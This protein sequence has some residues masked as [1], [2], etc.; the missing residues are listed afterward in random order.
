MT[1]GGFYKRSA[2]LNLGPRGLQESPYKGLEAYI[3]HET[4]GLRPSTA[5]WHRIA[6]SRPPLRPFRTAATFSFRRSATQMPSCEASA[7]TAWQLLSSRAGKADQ[8]LLLR[9]AN[10]HVLQ[11]RGPLKGRVWLLQA[12]PIH[13]HG[14]RGAG[15][16]LR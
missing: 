14:I 16:G 5:T 2:H 7:V 13:V 6:G 15:D 8:Q 12:L 4:G 11:L 9:I 10:P 3:W 1:F